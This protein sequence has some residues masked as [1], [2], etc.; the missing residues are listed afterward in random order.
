MEFILY[1][2]NTSTIL[3]FIK[4]YTVYNLCRACLNFKR[5]K[6]QA[7]VGLLKVIDKYTNIL[8]PY[9]DGVEQ[10]TQLVALQAEDGSQQ[11]AVPVIDPHTGQVS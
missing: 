8:L 6:K 7:F 4:K 3:F 2:N 5:I 9:L 1:T 11:L 10:A